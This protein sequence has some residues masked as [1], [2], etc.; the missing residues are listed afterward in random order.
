MKTFLAILM[1][2]IG[3]A[4]SMGVAAVRIK[5]LTRLDG[6]RESAL[7]GYGLVVGLSGTGDSARNLATQQ[8]VSNM[9]R[10]FGIQ[11]S[12]EAMS[13]RN[14]A[15]VLVSSTMPA[16]LRAG[17]RLDVNVA[18]IGDAR[19]L[20]GGTLLMTP[21]M[22]ADRKIY[23]TAQGA[24]TVGGY[25]FEQ[26]GSSAQKN[27]PTAATVPEG[28]I[29][30]T[31]LVAPTVASGGTLD[32]LLRRTDYTTAVRVSRAIAAKHPA[33]NPE[34]VDSGRV[35]LVVGDSGP[36]AVTELLASIENLEVEPDMAARVVVNERTGTVVS[37]GSAWISAV[38][39]TQGDIRVAI[40]ERNRISQPNG[41]L[42]NPGNGVQSLVVPEAQIQVNEENVQ[43][44]ELPQG[45]T[46]AELV[47]ALRAMR[48]SARDVIAIL[49]GIQR[50]GALHAELV[51]Q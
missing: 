40:V 38:S 10:E 11:V 24:L 45:A 23:A 32:L 20:A 35:R 41:V 5:D 37:G 29:A 44:V 21:L 12:P 46:I 16:S 30:E 27:F 6:G 26:S 39:V 13:A 31:T 33:L 50:A 47:S 49:Q 7:M 48:T 18:A 17:D 22:G 42:V 19:S 43:S 36:A 25:R 1:L 28:A 34:A 9:L 2:A 4:P 51:I 14:V 8:T 15:A 3:C